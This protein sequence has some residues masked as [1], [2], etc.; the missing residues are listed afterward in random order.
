MPREE[1]G[2]SPELL[3]KLDESKRVRAKAWGDKKANDTEDARRQYVKVFAEYNRVYEL[4]F[5]GLD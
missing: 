3:K 1:G 2:N 5:P 4:M